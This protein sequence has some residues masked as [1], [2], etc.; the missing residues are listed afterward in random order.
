MVTKT[1]QAQDLKKK[2]KKWISI[3][4]S[5]E[6]NNQE[7]GETYVEETEQALG[8]VVEVNLT[9]LTRDPKKQNFNAYFQVKEIKNGQAFTI[10]TGY[11]LQVAQLKR[12]TRKGKNKLDDSFIYKSKDGKTVTIKPIM[13]T[14]T[15]TYKTSLQGLR[16]ASR[17]FLTEYVKNKTGSQIMKEIMDGNLQRDIKNAVKKVSPIINCTIKTA[18]IKD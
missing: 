8:R 6:F 5:P 1:T 13:I 14:R 4:A 7:I 18:L 16:K 10:L 11:Q 9:M 3:M 12:I 2:K 17:E 15:L